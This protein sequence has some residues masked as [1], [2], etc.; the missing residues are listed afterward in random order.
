MGRTCAAEEGATITPRAGQGPPTTKQPIEYG[1]L[2]DLSVGA[3]DVVCNADA[4][5]LRMY[6]M[7]SDTRGMVLHRFAV[8]HRLPL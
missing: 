3:V 1:T 7:R 4:F 2:A 5:I 8:G 6:R